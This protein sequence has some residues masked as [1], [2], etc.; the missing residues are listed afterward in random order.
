MMKKLIVAVLVLCSL[1]LSAQYGYPNDIK[2]PTTHRNVDASQTMGIP[3]DTLTVP[4]AVRKKP[5][6]AFKGSSL[7][8]WDT[9]TLVWTLYSA[10]VS[11][12]D[13]A[14]VGSGFR[15]LKPGTQEL[16]TLFAGFGIVRDSTTNTNG[17][18][19]KIDTSGSGLSTVAYALSLYNI[20]NGSKQASLVSGTNIKTING[21]SVLG[22][23]DLTV[24][25]GVTDGS[26]NDVTVAG[27]NWT[28]N[29][30]AQSKVLNQNQYSDQSAWLNTNI[31]EKV[32][33]DFFGV[34]SAYRDGAT[35]LT[36]SGPSGDTILFFGGWTSPSTVYRQ[37]YYSLD[38]GK[39]KVFLGLTP[40]A[41]Q[42]SIVIVKNKV[43]GY[44]LKIGGDYLSTDAQKKEVWR[45]KTPSV[46]SSWVRVTDLPGRSVI[47]FDAAFLNG[48]I[49][50]Y[51]GQYSTNWSD[52]A[53][54]TVLV[55]PDD[56][57]TWNYHSHGNGI[58]NRNISHISAEFE[59]EILFAGGGQY[60]EATPGNRTYDR[61]TYSTKDFL[62]FKTE[63]PMP[64]G[65]GQY[66][67]VQTWDGK[68][69]SMFGFNNVDNNTNKVLYFDKSRRWNVAA[70]FD[71]TATAIN[72]SHAAAATVWKDRI[73]ILN[74]NDM[75]KAFWLRR[76]RFITAENDIEFMTKIKV[77][78]ITGNATTG[79]LSFGSKYSG[80]YQE[81]FKID[82]ANNR[83]YFA[84]PVV[85]N[86]NLGVGST[87][88][89][90]SIINFNYSG[91]SGLIKYDANNFT[92]NH[93]GNDLVLFQY[94]GPIKYN[95]N[96][97][98]QLTGHSLIC[99]DYYDS[100]L[101][102]ALAGVSSSLTPGVT[103]IVGGTT[104]N[105][106]YN[107]SNVWTE[108]N[109]L[110]WD[111]TNQLIQTGR[112]FRVKSG[113]TFLTETS[114]S[115][116]TILGNSVKRSA[117]A[118][119]VQKDA[120]ADP[121]SY[122]RL[123]YQDG[124]TFHT[125]FT[126]AIGTSVPET[127]NQAAGIDLSKNFYVGDKTNKQLTVNSSGKITK[128][129]NAAPADLDIMLGS[130]SSGAIE[131]GT[132]KAAD[133]NVSANELQLDYT[134]MQ[135]ANPTQPGLMTAAQ[136]ARLDSN[137][138]FKAG[139]GANVNINGTADTITFSMKYD[140]TALASF[141][142]G[143]GQAGDTIAFSTST[144]YGSFYNSGSDTLIITSAQVVLQGTSPSVLV[145]LY[146][147]DSLNVTAGAT[148]MVAA[149]NTITNTATGTAITSLSNTKIPPGNWVWLKTD[150]VTTKPTYL[151]FTLLGYK[152]RVYP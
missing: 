48:N 14:N 119:E 68:V 116:S 18:T 131:K 71:S 45:T 127:N 23:G 30:V 31:F 118:N 97:H 92:F 43:T 40:W 134:N 61:T 51:G 145:N 139:E 140:T 114:S 25:G 62:T 26:K 76:S 3:N 135:K 52:G 120:S 94:N 16:K 108:S 132:V 1:Q 50:K 15:L 111:N 75:D 96:W 110:Q 64:T 56:G 79:V 117:T 124:I 47:L 144:I 130:T 88:A 141:G 19:D 39:T 112:G 149:G 7:Y 83:T 95:G 78:T 106:G 20:L 107:S 136:A 4:T 80:S 115:L 128:Y 87:S 63:Q 121:G 8:R 82:G 125:N 10:G 9:T 99:R 98:S 81:Y 36:V 89:S 84:K 44:Y 12:T 13:N 152:K 70:N 67:T 46:M 113:Y 143:G 24:S 37:V 21:A 142:G 28:I 41:A 74:G 85:I 6:I 150:T 54:D 137:I 55:T 138:N 86:G 5:H 91:T 100:T 148:K 90:N 147:N 104:M 65:G 66:P 69:W 35:A 126:G 105:I 58:F 22:S 27:D 57:V 123:N 29:K 77:D 32:N 42:H 101:A 103:P 72:V 133:F 33:D 2:L 53:T 109:N 129:G 17:I 60:D 59:D 151:S 11:G 49:Y 93:S 146:W 122:F 73:V 102:V 38:G 34:D